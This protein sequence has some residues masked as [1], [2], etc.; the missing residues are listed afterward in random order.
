MA[1]WKS[2]GDG[3]ELLEPSGFPT[4]RELH[5]LVE[6]APQ[7]LPLAGSPRLAIVGSE[8][9][10]GSNYADLI[11]IEPSGRLVIIEVKLSRNAEA[12]R[13]VVAQALSYA[14]FLQGLTVAEVEEGVLA[15]HL[16]K[17]GE[18]SLATAAQA[19]SQGFGFDE[20][21]FQIALA[22]NLALG[23]FRLVFVLDAAPAELARLVE[24][25]ELVSS[26]RLLIDLVS[27]ASYELNGSQ[28]VIPQRVEAERR[29][30]R[31]QP[32]VDRPHPIDSTIVAGSDEFAASIDTAPVE[33]RDEL[34]RLLDWAKELEADGL[35]RLTTT[36]GAN[37]WMMNLVLPDETVGLVNIW[38]LNGA[39][40]ALWRSVFQRRAPQSIASIEVLTGAEIGSGRTLRTTDESVLSAIRA[41]Y[42]EA[43]ATR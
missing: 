38:N 31:E 36:V 34:R 20:G 21:A 29:E 37:R 9:A 30:P 5:E 25:L 15:R 14:A 28:V 33:S 35:T 26:D 41:A 4:E 39:S 12:R 7:I 40:L 11:G 42:E 32:T 10:L 23:A 22:D 24:Y 1:V 2:D 43:A 3:W 13:A 6:R 17:R 18:Q 19:A 8:V 16:A 27:V